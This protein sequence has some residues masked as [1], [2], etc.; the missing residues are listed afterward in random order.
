M[1]LQLFHSEFPHKEILFSFFIS[2]STHLEVY[3]TLGLLLFLLLFL[4]SLLGEESSQTIEGEE[5]DTKTN[6]CS[7]KPQSTY[8]DREET[9]SVHYKFVCDERY[10]QRKDRH[11]EHRAGKAPCLASWRK[12]TQPGEFCW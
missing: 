3:R 8:R 5:D 7:Q 4:L 10:S 11:I 9:G 2:V 1:T 6:S 12:M